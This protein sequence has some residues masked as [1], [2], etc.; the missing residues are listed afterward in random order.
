MDAISD[1]GNGGKMKL[2]KSP[3]LNFIILKILEIG[4]IVF[5]PYWIGKFALSF[6][7]LSN[8]FP[9]VDVVNMWFI[10]FAIVFCPLAIIAILVILIVMNW[11]AAKNLTK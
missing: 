11:D 7:F 3:V 9:Y 2:T 10:G 1:K 6:E 4:G 5:V 8:S